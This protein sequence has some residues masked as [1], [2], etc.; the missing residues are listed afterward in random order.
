MDRDGQ[1]TKPIALSPACTVTQTAAMVSRV[2][3]LV[4]LLLIA[5]DRVNDPGVV[6]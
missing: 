1:D 5:E 3:L 6:R 4:P 2:D